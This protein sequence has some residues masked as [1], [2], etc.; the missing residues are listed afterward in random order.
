[1]AGIMSRFAAITLLRLA[2]VFATIAVVAG[3]AL[4]LWLAPWPIDA[5]AAIASAAAWTAWVEKQEQK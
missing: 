4:L 1:M 5:L 2:G 3:V